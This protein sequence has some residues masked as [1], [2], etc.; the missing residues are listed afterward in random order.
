[1]TDITNKIMSIETKAGDTER[2]ID[3]H[4]LRCSITLIGHIMSSCDINIQSLIPCPIS[5]PAD[6]KNKLKNITPKNVKSSEA[7]AILF[8]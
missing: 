2:N 1:M 5:I 6:I 7:D 4:A 3:C 8:I